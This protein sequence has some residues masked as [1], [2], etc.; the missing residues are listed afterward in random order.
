MG[1]IGRVPLLN[2]ATARAVFYQAATFVAVA[3]LIW[4]F[5][6][7]TIDNM[8]QRGM[9]AGF[10]FL[11]VSAGFNIAFTLIPYREGNSYFRVFQVGVAN[12]LLWRRSPSCWRRFSAW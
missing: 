8:S 1:G 4:Y 6:T 3:G 2:N 12:T 10:D 7:N 9:S 11:D 5:V